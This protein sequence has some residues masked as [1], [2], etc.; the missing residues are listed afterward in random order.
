MCIRGDIL[1]KTVLALVSSICFLSGCSFQYDKDITAGNNSAVYDID[2][3]NITDSDVNNGVESEPVVEPYN[4]EGEPGWDIHDIYISH[5]TVCPRE[6]YPELYQSMEQLLADRAELQYSVPSPDIDIYS[7]DV[8]DNGNGSVYFPLKNKEINSR[9]TVKEQLSKIYEENYIDK[10]LLPYYF[11][12]GNPLYL[13]RDG[14]LYCQNVA[15][16][17][18]TLRDDWTIRRINDN[19]YYIHGFE[20]ADTEVMVILTVIRSDGEGS[21]F[22]ISGEIEISF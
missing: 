8:I 3:D 15:A 17:V 5:S 20:D 1:K 16:I 9:E 13:E 14:Q 22:L 7:S 2:N 10:V 11:E 12:S 18:L 21:E 6:E 4:D 19:Y